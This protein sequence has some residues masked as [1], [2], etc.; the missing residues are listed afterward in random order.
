MKQKFFKMTAILFVVVTIGTL[1]L[2]S[3]CTD[4][5]PKPALP[6]WEDD[7]NLEFVLEDARSA[8]KSFTF[9]MPPIGG[10]I[11]FNYTLKEGDYIPGREHEFIP[12]VKI[13][14]RGAEQ[15]FYTKVTS[16]QSFSYSSPGME[17]GSVD[18]AHP[19]TVSVVNDWGVYRVN[20]E[21][22]LNIEHVDRHGYDEIEYKDFIF[23]QD[24]YITVHKEYK[25]EK[26]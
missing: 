9:R 5:N 18:Y 13:L 10:R 17:P 2:F 4:P 11:Y 6:W 3:G 12:K 22:Y 19:E 25:N 7:E 26:H 24:I 14:H 15:K 20:L 21:S 8:E 1:F 23:T 16:R